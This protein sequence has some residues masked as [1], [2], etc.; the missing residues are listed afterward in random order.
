MLRSLY[1]G[2]SGMKN[3]QTKLDVIGNNIANVNTYGFKKGRVT[4]KDLMSQQLTAA[5]AATNI[6]SGMNAKQVGLG[7]ALSSIDTIH[8]GGSNQTTGRTLDLAL[9]GDGFFVVG[10]IKDS[11]KVK[12]D[13]KTGVSNDNTITEPI[14]SAMDVSY[15]RAGN[16]YLDDMGYLVTSDGYY[17]VGE[18]GDKTGGNQPSWGN[19]NSNL[20]G[21][22]QIPPTAK[23]FNIGPDGSVSFVDEDS[24]LRNA[25][26]IRVANFANEGG[27]EKVGGNLF[28]ESSNSGKI[29]TDGIQGIQLTELS[30]PGENGS[31]TIMT[32]FL[33]MSN[34]DLADEFTDMIVAQ[35]G[36]QSNTKIITTSDEILQELMNLK[37]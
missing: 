30:V 35:R 12:I 31:A 33:E 4:Y 5:S 16:F 37:R 32:G 22:I 6:T 7:S 10:T 11:T 24:Q 13:T 2:V 23:S 14:D 26:K 18:A 27:L 19:Q 28:K 8:T 21:L 36:F 3:F 9:A 1:S 34:V 15:T 17:L 25:G 20:A 29:D